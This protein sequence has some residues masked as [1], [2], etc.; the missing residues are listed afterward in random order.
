MTSYIQPNVYVKQ[1]YL[2]PFASE[3]F[4]F[5]QCD[6]ARGALQYKVTI[7]VIMATYWVPDFHDIKGFSDH[8]SIRY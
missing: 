6:S 1:G 3:M 2:S 8:L 7:F 4:D 5:L